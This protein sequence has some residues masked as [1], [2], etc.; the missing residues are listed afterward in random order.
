MKNNSKKKANLKII[1]ISGT[2]GKV[3]RKIV[4]MKKL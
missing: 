1:F 4:K 2:T 3:S